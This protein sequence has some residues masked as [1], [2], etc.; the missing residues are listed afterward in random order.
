VLDGLQVGVGIWT[1]HSANHSGTHSLVLKHY[2]LAI[3]RFSGQATLKV[4][5]KCLF[6]LR[7]NA[8]VEHVLSIHKVLGS[9]VRTKTNM[10]VLTNRVNLNLD[11]RA[12]SAPNYPEMGIEQTRKMVSN[13]NL[14]HSL[15]KF[16][17]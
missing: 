1:Q 11:S 7:C 10:Y 4:L 3:T 9:I 8:V 17:N 14:H 5:L 13:F 2:I 12:L 15:M 6:A 16:N